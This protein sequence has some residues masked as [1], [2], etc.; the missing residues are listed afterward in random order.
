MKESN[1]KEPQM[2]FR[3]GYIAI[4]GRPNVGKSTL[5]NQILAESIVIVSPKPQT[6]RNR[7]LGVRHL[8]DAQMIF[9]DTPGIH[10]PFHKLGEFMVETALRAIPDAEVILFMVDVSAMPSGARIF[11]WTYSM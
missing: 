1:A 7:I 8:P 10:S 11:S 4:V 3:S 2:S 9:V 5:L 6:T